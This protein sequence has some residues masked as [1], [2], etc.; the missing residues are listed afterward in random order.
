MVSI[1]PSQNLNC[2]PLSS[3]E[4]K[5][6]PRSLRYRHRT[7]AV[8]AGQKD[9]YSPE[10]FPTRIQPKT[11]RS[12]RG[13]AAPEESDNC[14]FSVHQHPNRRWKSEKYKSLLLGYLVKT[15]SIDLKSVLSVLACLQSI[16]TSPLRRS[17]WKYGC[18]MH[19]ILPVHPITKVSTISTF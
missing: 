8:F 18:H 2:V 15:K 7:K 4:P 3:R 13:G 1:R 10:E 11:Q 6:R 16:P 14:T 9:F 19:Q 12:V 17:C 5:H